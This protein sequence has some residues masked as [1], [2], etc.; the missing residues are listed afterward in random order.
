[1]AALYFGMQGVLSA[2]V[3]QAAKSFVPFRT[4][5]RQ[6]HS[7]CRVW[8]ELQ[9]KPQVPPVNARSSCH[10]CFLLYKDAF[11]EETSENNEASAGEES[12][13]PARLKKLKQHC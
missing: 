12:S 9:T 13:Q 6:F 4:S 11:R 10:Q 7:S 2:T 3:S 1:M 8:G 5:T